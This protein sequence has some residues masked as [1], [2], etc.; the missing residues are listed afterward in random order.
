M[1]VSAC[2]AKPVQ[3]AL[4]G[5]KN[6]LPAYRLAISGEALR[7]GRRGFSAQDPGEAYGPHWLI[8]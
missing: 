5:M 1:Y 3:Q 4:Q 2:F 6:R 7:V 8:R